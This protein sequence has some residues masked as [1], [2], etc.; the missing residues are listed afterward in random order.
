MWVNGEKLDDKRILKKIMRSLS[1]KFEY[2]VEAIR[3][4]NDMFILVVEGLMSALCSHE[5]NINQR[6]DY[7]NLKH[8]L[9]IDHLQKVVVANNVAKVVVEV[10][11]EKDTTNSI[12]EMETI[13][14]L[15]LEEGAMLLDLKSH[16]QCFR[17]KKYEHRK[18]ECSTKLHNEQVEQ[19]NKVKVEQNSILS[20]NVTTS[21]V[22]RKDV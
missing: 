9:Q 1:A 4:G 19:A 13:T 8:F 16:I 12:I 17:C 5:Q 6:I 18:L 10:E 14:K 20:Y 7:S 22:D 11:V 2:V 21:N 15:I 3:E